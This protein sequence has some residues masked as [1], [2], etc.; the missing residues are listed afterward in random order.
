MTRRPRVVVAAKLLPDALAKLAARCDVIDAIEADPS[1]LADAVASADGLVVNSQV[2]VDAR[3]LEASAGSLRVVAV[4]GVGLDKVDVE[5][6]GRQ[7]VTVLNRPGAA[8]QAVAELA[9]SFM[10]Q[11][12]RP[13]QR[14]AA[15]YRSGAFK[16]ARA[17]THGVELRTCTI[18]IIGM[19]RI[20]SAVGRICTQGFGCRVIY[21][22]I[23]PIEDLDFAAEFVARDAL[24]ESA[25]IVTLHV[26]LDD[27]TRGMLD[28]TALA[29]MQPTAYLIN[30]ARGPV[31]DAEALLAALNAER[32]AGAALDVTD[33]EPLPPTH[34]LLDH[35][36]C[37]VT[38]HIAA[39]THGGLA[40]MH[41]VVS[42]L[43]DFFA[44]RK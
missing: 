39:R 8:T 18:G 15:Q 22:D 12:L 24:L 3:L 10:L 44:P 42:E 31:V 6:A 27:T 35:P 17:N 11:L 43:L 23:R 21:H 13:T 1:V 34:P 36:R 5:A 29:R 14:M 9:T 32:L 30:T 4:T 38:P 33:P 20:G 2:R 7:G 41:D 37:I 26:P 19:G 28:E 16:A 40:R 25:D